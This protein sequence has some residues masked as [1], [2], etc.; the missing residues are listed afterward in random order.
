MKSIKLNYSVTHFGT[1]EWADKNENFING[2]KHNCK[3]CYSKEMAIRFKRKTSEDWDCEEIRYGSL[4]KKIRKYNGII[5]FPS[6]H[7]IHPDNIQYSIMFLEKLLT[8]GNNI[9]VVTKPHEICV[10]MICNK[11]KNFN[12]NIIF[13]FSM[14]SCNSDILKFWEPGAPSF[15]ERFRSLK[16]AYKKGFKTSVSCEPMLDNNIETLVK[17]I[18]PYITDSIWIGKANFL[19]RRLKMNGVTDNITLK[20]ANNLIKMQTDHNI[21]S[22]YYKLRNNEL[23][24]WKESITKVILNNHIS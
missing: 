12:N 13:R 16:F 17:I 2:C 1:K 3:Y 23:I 14:G 20:E 21:I 15:D 10:K 8:S 7:D 22:L 11:F 19:L 5:M 6:S 24:M 18:S 4:E 9:L